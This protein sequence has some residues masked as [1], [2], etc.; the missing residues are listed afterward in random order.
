MGVD[1]SQTV[2]ATENLI[3]RYKQQGYEFATIPEMAKPAISR[4]PSA[5]S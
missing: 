3:K 5:I 2:L 1:R 4:Q